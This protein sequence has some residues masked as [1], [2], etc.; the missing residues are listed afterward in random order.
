[1]DKLM[2]R[3]RM[4]E[5]QVARRNKRKAVSRSI[6]AKRERMQDLRN[7][8]AA[9]QLKEARKARAEDWKLG[10]LAPRRDL[11]VDPFG[12]YWGSISIARARLSIKITPEE[13]RARAAWCGGPKFLCIR[14]GDRV[15]VTEGTFK[16]KIGYIDE[17]DREFMVVSIKDTLR[18]SG[19]GRTRVIALAPAGLLL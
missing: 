7:K 8:E 1:M 2:R 9:H 6:E 12:N 3:V 13:R 16:D 5:G 10:P 18:V 15:V 17:I 11:N 4:A 19:R 14:P